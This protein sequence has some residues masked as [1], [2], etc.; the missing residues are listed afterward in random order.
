MG[1]GIFVE[2]D[3][4]NGFDDKISADM[5]PFTLA[6]KIRSDGIDRGLR[7]ILITE[8]MPDMS[9]RWNCRRLRAIPKPWDWWLFN[10][11]CFLEVSALQKLI[12]H[13]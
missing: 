10:W 2:D 12:R 5:C 6:K 8:K 13:T 11:R 9:K 3:E 1:T 7:G 4:A